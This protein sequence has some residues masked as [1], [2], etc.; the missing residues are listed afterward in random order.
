MTPSG[1]SAIDP[2]AELS[3]NARL[4]LRLGDEAGGRVDPARIM[5]R[6]SNRPARRAFDE[7]R[8]KDCLDGDGWITRAGRQ[9]LG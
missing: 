6:D 7:L 9:V 3:D 4:L 2:R 1:Q 5:H 8:A